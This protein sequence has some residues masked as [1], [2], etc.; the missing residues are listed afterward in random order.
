MDI[1]TTTIFDHPLFS[2]DFIILLENL[3]V[4][5]A[6]RM[7]AKEYSFGIPHTLVVVGGRGGGGACKLFTTTVHNYIKMRFC[8]NFVMHL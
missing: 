5:K 8:L 1:L 7:Q 4:D 6:F 3:Q 2:P